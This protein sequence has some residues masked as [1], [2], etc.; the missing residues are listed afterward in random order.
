MQKSKPKVSIIGAGNV[1]STFAYALMIRGI[2]REIVIIDQNEEKAKG[3]CM[4]LNH[5]MSFAHPTEIYSAGYEGCKNSDIVVITAGAKQKPG[6][7]RLDLVQ[8]NV[9]VFKEIVPQILKHAKDAIIIVVTNPVDILTYVT[10]KISGLPS[11]RVL[12][13]GTVL[14][15]SRFHYLISQH[16][17]IDPRNV[18][19]YIIGEHGDTELPVWTS[20]T[21]GGMEIKKYCPTCKN[22]NHCKREEELEK[23][24][25]EVKSSAYR[26]I[27]TKG[28]TYYAIG[29]ALERIVEAILRD[30]N[31]VLP[32]STL[33][34]D[35]YDVSDIYLSVPSVVNKNGVEQFLRI[36]LSEKEQGLFKKSAHSLKEIINGIKF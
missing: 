15:T 27:E 23:L 8:T 19:A 25:E 22:F 13:S 30:E 9:D 26:I 14:D 32:V 33:I 12:G 16:C 2:A 34:K 1:G 20:A 7:T 5:G 24:F 31:S 21:I 29:L 36:E 3:E 10:M 11:N 35:Y 18:H 28:A 4:D 6:Q 17:E